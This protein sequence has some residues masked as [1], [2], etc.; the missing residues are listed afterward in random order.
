MSKPS[1][2]S[3]ISPYVQQAI[4]EKAER[5][6][7]AIDTRLSAFDAVGKALDA[8]VELSGSLGQS[9][10]AIA[11]TAPDP[12]IAAKLKKLRRAIDDAR[13]LTD[14]IATALDVQ[15]ARERAA[16]ERRAIVD[17]LT[18]AGIDPSSLSPGGEAE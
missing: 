10:P 6:L 14:E 7:V 13:A 2:S 9:T 17:A 11:Q 15:T 3:A 4:R 1:S 16:E 5:D 18:A 12:S 8:L